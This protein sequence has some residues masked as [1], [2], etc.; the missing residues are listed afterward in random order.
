MMRK[1]LVSNSGETGKR[2]G[3]VFFCNGFVLR[4]IF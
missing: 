4:K 1:K 3:M 2:N